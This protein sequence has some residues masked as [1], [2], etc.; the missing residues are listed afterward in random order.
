MATALSERLNQNNITLLQMLDQRDGYR[1]QDGNGSL[2]KLSPVERRNHQAQVEGNGYLIEQCLNRY[3]TLLPQM[4]EAISQQ[5]AKE[6]ELPPEVHCAHVWKAQC[7]V[8]Y[9]LQQRAAVAGLEAAGVTDHH[10]AE[11]T[12]EPV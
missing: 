1:A 12:E 8:A 11:P 5:Q 10:G 6:K 3:R 7:D 2:E 4:Q 9:A